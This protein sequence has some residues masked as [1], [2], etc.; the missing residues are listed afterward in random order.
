MVNKIAILDMVWQ[1]ALGDDVDSVW[2][3]FLK[4]GIGISETGLA[5]ISKPGTASEKM[6]AFVRKDLERLLKSMG[7]QLNTRR[8]CLIVGT[9][10]GSRLEA[11]EESLSFD[12]AWLN[13]LADEFK[14][15]ESML[16]LTACSSGSD[17]IALAM[18]L[19]QAGYTD[20]CISGGVDVITA[21]KQYAHQALGT[22]SKKQLRSF[23][24]QRDGTLL[25]EGSAFFILKRSGEYSIK[26]KAWL[27]ASGLA[28]AASGL[29]MPESKGHSLALAIKKTLKQAQ[30][31]ADDIGLIHAHGSGTYL[32]DL[33]EAKAFSLFSK[34]AITF[35]TKGRLGHT[36]GATGA[37][38]LLA[39]ILALLTQQVPS[40]AHLATPMSAFPTILA[41]HNHRLHNIRYGISTTLGFGGFDSCLLAGI[42]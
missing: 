38:G 17:A 15:Q 41:Q 33:V 34:T 11:A 30:L 16:V 21:A 10:F 36:L 5:Q 1:T 9:G 24:E 28:N 13:S 35:A 3:L 6:Y 40:I 42:D 19:L 12:D 25:G 29:T 31:H 2:N 18:E 23:D 32:N 7:P 8:T 22:L 20:A 14:L 39:L 26:P 27:Y 4:D 37:I